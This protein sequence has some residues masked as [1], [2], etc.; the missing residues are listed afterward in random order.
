MTQRLNDSMTQWLTDSLIHWFNDSMI[1]RLTDSLTQWLNEWLNDSTTH[2]LTE[3]LTQW[4]TNPLTNWFT[5]SVTSWLSD[6]VTQWLKDSLTYTL[7][8]QSY[9]QDV[10]SC[11]HTTHILV[12]RSTFFLQPRYLR[13]IK[14]GWCS[15]ISSHPSLSLLSTRVLNLDGVGGARLNLLSKWL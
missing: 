15:R 5:D 14:A 6:S 1:H 8:H 12:H 11:Q 4:L 7:T 10:M 2:W 9:P 3:S 13:W